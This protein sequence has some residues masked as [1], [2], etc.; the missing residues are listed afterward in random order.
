MKARSIYWTSCGKQVLGLKMTR[1][2]CLALFRCFDDIAMQ[3]DIDTAS[4]HIEK[5][6]GLNESK[7]ERVGHG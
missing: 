7:P 2:V 4:G 3:L 5:V 6:A 1:K